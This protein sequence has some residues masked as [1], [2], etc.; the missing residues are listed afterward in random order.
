[1]FLLNDLELTGVISCLD[2]LSNRKAE[3]EVASERKTMQSLLEVP[4]I[5][6]R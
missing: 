4:V 3:R 5:L 2:C 6:T 1:M